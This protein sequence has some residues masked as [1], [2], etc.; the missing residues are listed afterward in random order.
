MFP[1]VAFQLMFLLYSVSVKSTSGNGGM[2]SLDRL[3]SADDH[4]LDD[5]LYLGLRLDASTH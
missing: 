5:G 3:Y 4:H 2:K 1:N